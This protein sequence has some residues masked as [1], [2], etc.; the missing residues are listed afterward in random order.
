MSRVFVINEYDHD[1]GENYTI[2]VCDS[3]VRGVEML[4]EYYGKHDLISVVHNAVDGVE[5]TMD[6]M[7]NDPLS[8]KYRVTVAFLRFDVN[9]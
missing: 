7:V 8:D 4:E 6:L 1:D 5:Q 9:K 3:L 2:G